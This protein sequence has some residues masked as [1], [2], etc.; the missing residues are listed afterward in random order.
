MQLADNCDAQTTPETDTNAGLFLRLLVADI[1]AVYEVNRKTCARILLADL[2]RWLASG[3]FKSSTSSSGAGAGK[4]NGSNSSNNAGAEGSMVIDTSGGAAGSPL[5]LEN[6]I[7]EVILGQYLFA[8]PSAPHKSVYYQSLI[9]ELCKI[10]PQTV[11]PALGKCIRKLY[12]GLGAAAAPAGESKISLGP[13]QTRRFAEWFAVH[14][15]NFGFHW[16]WPEWCV[17][18]LF[19]KAALLM[20]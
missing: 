2:P 4:V 9:G 18:S 7:V 17:T 11:A 3:A 8:A 5:V 10:S 13:E 16:R 20:S 19:S 12:A 14:L 1:I 15:S 6:L